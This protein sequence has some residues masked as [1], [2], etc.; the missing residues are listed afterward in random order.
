[1]IEYSIWLSLVNGLSK[2]KKAM[3]LEKMGSAEV[4]YSSYA[5]VIMKAYSSYSY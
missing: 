5:S 1:M 3:L 2:K 4:I